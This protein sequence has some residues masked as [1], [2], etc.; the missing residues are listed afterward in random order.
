MNKDLDINAK[1]TLKDHFNVLKF[2]IAFLVLKY[3]CLILF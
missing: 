2:V 3:I 1:I